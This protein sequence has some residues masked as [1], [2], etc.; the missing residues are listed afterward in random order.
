[1][2]RFEDESTHLIQVYG[3]MSLSTSIYVKEQIP[4]Y[5]IYKGMYNKVAY[6]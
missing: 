4:N 2:V 1:M 3:E 5:P 6:L